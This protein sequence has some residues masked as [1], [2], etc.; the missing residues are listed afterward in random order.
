MEQDGEF[1]Q[2][3]TPCQSIPATF[4]IQAITTRKKGIC[5]CPLLHQ[6]WFDQ[7]IP[8]HRTLDHV[9]AI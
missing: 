9:K 6:K 1:E 8:W 2:Y 4:K 3:L 7:I 5:F